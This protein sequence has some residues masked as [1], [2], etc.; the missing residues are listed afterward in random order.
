MG[1]IP[2]HGEG[3]VGTGVSRARSPGEDIPGGQNGHSGNNRG[4]NPG[5]RLDDGQSISEDLLD[6]ELGIV[7]RDHAQVRGGQQFCMADGL[8]DVLEAA[9]RGHRGQVGRRI[10]DD[11][12][13]GGSI[14]L[15]GLQRIPREILHRILGD[16]D[17][18]GALGREDRARLKE[19]L[20]GVTVVDELVIGTADE[21][22]AILPQ[23]EGG[24]ND[25]GVIDA[26]PHIR[27]LQHELRERCGGCDEDH[28]GIRIAIHADTIV[29]RGGQAGLGLREVTPF[30]RSA[31]EEDVRTQSRGIGNRGIVHPQLTE[32]VVRGSDDG[33]E[34]NGQGRLD[35]AHRRPL[36]ER[37]AGAVDRRAERSQVEVVCRGIDKQRLQRREGNRVGGTDPGEIG[38]VP[39]EHRGVDHRPG[40]G[41]RIDRDAGD[42]IRH[43]VVHDGGA[44][45]VGDGNADSASRGSAVQRVVHN[46]AERHRSQRTARS[47]SLKPDTS[48]GIIRDD[49]VRDV[50][51]RQ[52]PLGIERGGVDRGTGNG[53]ASGR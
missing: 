35:R 45:I 3:R 2:P 33:R 34:G 39:L 5:T 27:Q 9:Q 28:I 10:P 40:R 15:V 12:E 11:P 7:P 48:P 44:G 49:I 46:A 51:A 41:T 20:P 18:V 1:I 21:G 37:V 19:D 43:D 16:G 4:G 6:A 47:R 22:H 52:Q 42:R 53:L 17:G 24:I 50:D 25:R 26:H 14:G 38:G 36:A 31:I 32:A 30:D 29:E 8:G 13:D 23:H